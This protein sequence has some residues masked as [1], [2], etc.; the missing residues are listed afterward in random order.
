MSSAIY[1]IARKQQAKKSSK[2]GLLYLGVI[3]IKLK[4]TFDKR[5]N[6]GLVFIS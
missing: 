5:F 6:E 1:Y 2:M 4:T 3:M